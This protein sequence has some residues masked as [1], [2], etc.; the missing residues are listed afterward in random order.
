M[1]A[2]VKSL[3]KKEERAQADLGD[4]VVETISAEDK[5]AERQ[6]TVLL[7]QWPVLQCSTFRSLQLN[8]YVFIYVCGHIQY[9]YV[10]L[11]FS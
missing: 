5:L 6:Y 7:L 8:K 9:I 1:T 10:Y 2:V 11:F 3:G 4:P